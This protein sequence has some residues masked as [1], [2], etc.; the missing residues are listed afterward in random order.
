MFVCKKKKIIKAEITCKQD[1]EPPFTTLTNN[2]SILWQHNTNW[3]S[4]SPDMPELYTLPQLLHF[5]LALHFSVNGDK[6]S[7]PK[8]IRPEV[9]RIPCFAF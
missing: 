7:L 4:F 3:I 1:F 5:S 2:S 8:T 6:N 9:F